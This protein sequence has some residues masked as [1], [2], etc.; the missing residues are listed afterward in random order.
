MKFNSMVSAFGTIKLCRVQNNLKQNTPSGSLDVVS[1]HCS[2]WELILCSLSFPTHQNLC[3][4]IWPRNALDATIASCKCL[5][6]AALLYGHL[7]LE[8][9]P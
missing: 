9:L 1:P 3:I 5:P 2:F 8:Y 6:V 7:S 4:L